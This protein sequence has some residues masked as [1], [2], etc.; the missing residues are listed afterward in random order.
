MYGRAGIT[1]EFDELLE[2]IFPFGK[3]RKEET[4]LGC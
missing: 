4:F 1:W 3:T 2:D